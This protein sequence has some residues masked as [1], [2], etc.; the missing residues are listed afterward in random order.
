M[1]MNPLGIWCKSWLNS[2]APSPKDTRG[3]RNVEQSE[4]NCVGLVLKI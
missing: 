4:S 2:G 1:W 3:E